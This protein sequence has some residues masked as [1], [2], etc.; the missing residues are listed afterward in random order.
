MTPEQIIIGSHKAMSIA[1]GVLLY[2]QELVT[3]ILN[4]EGMDQGM[5]QLYQQLDTMIR[6][7]LDPVWAELDLLDMMWT[8]R[9]GKT[10]TLERIGKIV[11]PTPISFTDE[12]SSAGKALEDFTIK[13]RSLEG[14]ADPARFKALHN[15]LSSDMTIASCS[16]F[17]YDDQMKEWWNG[18]QDYEKNQNQKLFNQW[19]RAVRGGHRQVQYGRGCFPDAAGFFWRTQGK[20][21]QTTTNRNEEDFDQA[22]NYYQ[23]QPEKPMVCFDGCYILDTTDLGA[24]DAALEETSPYD[25]D[26]TEPT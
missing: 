3:G 14:L 8:R 26:D 13:D 20:G 16:G 10:T 9:L 15:A 4:N 17:W 5:L 6:N 19:R 11:F 12:I 7:F 1:E 18:L 22:Y 21:V 24:G 25:I 2:K 23:E